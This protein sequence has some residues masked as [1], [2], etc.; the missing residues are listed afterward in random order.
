MDSKL[1]TI[2]KPQEIQQEIDSYN[3]SNSTRPPIVILKKIILNLTMGNSQLIKYNKIFSFICKIILKFSNN[4]GVKKLGMLIMEMYVSSTFRSTHNNNHNNGK[5]KNDNLDIE[6]EGLLPYLIEEAR[7]SPPNINAL[8]ILGSVDIGCMSLQLLKNYTNSLW[9]LINEK[10][11]C[12]DENEIFIEFIHL[13]IRLIQKIIKTEFNKELREDK[14]QIIF[15][16]LFKNLIKFN[17]NIEI[18]SAIS[19]TLINLTTANKYPFL[20]IELTIFHVS[21]I[22]SM[23]TNLRSNTLISGDLLLINHFNQIPSLLTLLTKFKI[24]NSNKSLRKDIITCVKPF[25]ND[26]DVSVIMNSIK[27][28][29]YF[30]DGINNNDKHNNDIND[31]E[32][33]FKI[34]IEIIQSFNKFFSNDNNKII[35]EDRT[36]FFD[37]LRNLILVIIKFGKLF[38]KHNYNDS[39]DI[40]IEIFQIL[41]EKF[42]NIN[43][44][45]DIE[46]YIIDTKLEILYLLSIEGIENKLIIEILFKLIKSSNNEISYK[47]FRTLG[48]L[49]VKENKYLYL[50]DSLID[51][52][53]INKNLLVISIFIKDLSIN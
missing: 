27:C 39:V 1:Y 43:E 12:E 45:I 44:E 8:H 23:I 41:I 5:E 15:N 10:L 2:L 4:E 16:K 30:L 52:I 17:N 20:K 22:I 7:S 34:A 48:N 9:I 18:S 33:N 28:V 3:L 21:K 26:N 50:M 24:E 49:I 29:I 51:Q 19:E 32:F 46:P 31:E 40:D 35:K 38:K 36:I 37:C 13:S 25:M 6:L 53:S 14:I 42:I 11:S 47:S